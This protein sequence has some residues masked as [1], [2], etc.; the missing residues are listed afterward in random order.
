MNST[1]LIQGAKEKYLQLR[2]E[3]AFFET[4][5]LDYLKFLQEQSIL[6]IK[7]EPSLKERLSYF[8]QTTKSP[9]WKSFYLGW[10]EGRVNF[11]MNDRHKQNTST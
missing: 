1:E 4:D 8:L 6:E 3:Q 2:L 9:H 11:Y 10:V 7:H 5:L